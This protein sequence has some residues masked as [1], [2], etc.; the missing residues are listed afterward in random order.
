M[1]FSQEEEKWG[2]VK[3]TQVMVSHLVHI[4]STLVKL[5]IDDLHQ[6]SCVGT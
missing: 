1:S 2:K 6:L 5:G 4:S 3:I